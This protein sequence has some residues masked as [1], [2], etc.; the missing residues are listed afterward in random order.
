MY[1][2]K[3]I[4]ILPDN[5]VY[6]EGYI[7][8]D[9]E[10]FAGHF[11]EDPLLPGIVELEIVKAALESA[12][13]TELDIKSVKRVRFRHTVRPGDF[14]SISATPGKKNRNAYTYTFTAEQIAAGSGI[15]TIG[16]QK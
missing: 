7:S 8:D 12:L 1:T 9:P 14:F 15:I 3:K 16:N 2:I 10:L 6:A 13:E 5:S 4:E 11:P